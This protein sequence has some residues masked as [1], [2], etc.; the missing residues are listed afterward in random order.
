M[1]CLEKLY[2]EE[3]DEEEGVINRVDGTEIIFYD[4]IQSFQNTK[5]LQLN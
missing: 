3:A 2:K 1:Q 5:R 4:K